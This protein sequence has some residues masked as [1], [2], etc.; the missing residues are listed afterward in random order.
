MNVVAVAFGCLLGLGACY[1]ARET[2]RVHRIRN[3]GVRVVGE[4]DHIRT[5]TDGD[6]ALQ[7]HPVV[8]FTL[9]GGKTVLAESATSMPGFCPLSPGEQVEIAY[10]PRRPELI[11]IPGFDGPANPWLYGCLTLFLAG[12]S[13]LFLFA[14]VI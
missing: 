4:V 9:P 10:H 3:H 6:G 12:C 13:A 14:A 7:H 2:A 11:V 5:D 1:G 8:R